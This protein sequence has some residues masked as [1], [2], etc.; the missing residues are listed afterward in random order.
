MKRYFV[1]LALI[2]ICQAGNSQTMNQLFDEFAKIEHTEHVKIGSITMKLAS[3]FTETMGVNS[4]DIFEFNKCDNKVKE[5]FTQAIKKL[6]DPGFE[7]MLTSNKDGNQT[8]VM[9]RAEDEMI[10]EIVILTTG[11]NNSLVRIQGK[12]KSSDIEKIMVKNGHG[13]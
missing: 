7:T 4:I 3:L 13:C 2:L 9:I 5:R 8:K 12:I 11:T 10:R 6:K 1:I